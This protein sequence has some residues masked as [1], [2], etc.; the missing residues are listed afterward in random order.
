MLGY[1]PHSQIIQEYNE[2][3]ARARQIANRLKQ[4][5][6]SSAESICEQKKST[7]HYIAL[8]QENKEKA[9]AGLEYYWSLISEAKAT[10]MQISLLQ[11][12][13]LDSEQLAHLIENSRK[14][15][16]LL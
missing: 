1:V 6:N 9:Q 16:V 7:K 10:Y 15:S 2:E 5:G 14:V 8:L 12:P 11:Q 13:D 3:I 4:S